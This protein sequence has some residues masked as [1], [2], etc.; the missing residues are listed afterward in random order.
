[1]DLEVVFPTA[2]NVTA[3]TFGGKWGRPAAPQSRTPAVF[4]QR[5]IRDA[6][7]HVLVR[8]QAQGTT[9]CM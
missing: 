5:S 8:P 6:H 7:V 1:M 2:L 4:T 9:S 3:C